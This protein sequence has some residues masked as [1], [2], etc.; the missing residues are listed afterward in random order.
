MKLE[1]KKILFIHNLDNNLAATVVFSFLNNN[2]QISMDFQVITNVS[3][4]ADII[5]ELG[6]AKN[7]GKNM[8]GNSTVYNSQM[9]LLTW[10]ASKLE[11]LRKV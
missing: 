8:P 6:N 9:K 4:G 2:L 11:Q 3:I 10:D 7:S 5:S 1:P